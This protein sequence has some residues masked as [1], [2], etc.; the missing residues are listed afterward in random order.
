MIKRQK[1]EALFRMN[2]LI[3]KYDLNSKLYTYLKEDKLYYSYYIIPDIKTLGCI[4]IIIYDK[5]Y[6]N[7]VKVFEE[8]YEAFVYHSIETFS[9][10]GKMLTLLFVSKD[11]SEWDFERPLKN[12]DYIHS[13][14]FN[15]DNNFGEFGDVFL[16]SDG[17]ALVRTDI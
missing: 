17:G 7:I 6:E 3:K 5:R 15:L 10:Y 14:V 8:K 4:N 12:E 1:E 13:Y 16:S 2:T 11:E 9:I